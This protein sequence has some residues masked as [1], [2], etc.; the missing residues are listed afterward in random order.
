MDLDGLVL[1]NRDFGYCK[2]TAHTGNSVRVKF[3]G[4]NRDAWYGVQV[5]AAQKDFRWTP[6]PAGLK[7]RVPDRGLCT[8]IEVPFQPSSAHGVHEYLVLFDGDAGE[9]ARLT[10]RELWPIPGSLA[11]TPLTRL[12]SLQGDSLP[13]FRARE[14]LLAAFQQVDRESANISALAASRVALLP[15]QAFVIGTVID[16]PLWRYILAD[17]VGLGKTIEAGAIAHQLLSENPD[18]RVLVLCPG[19]LSRQWLCE[20][21]LSFGGRAFRLLDL[22]DSSKVSLKAWPLV[23]SSL[24]VAARDYRARILGTQWDMVIVDEAHQLLW[25]DGHYGLVEQ[26]A[27]A[28]PRLLLLS[29]VPAR[30]RDTELM[31]LLRMIEPERYCEGSPVVD[32]FST[33]Y[34]A[35]STIGRRLRIV[36]RQLDDSEDVDHEQLQN[37]VHRLLSIDVLR[38]DADLRNLER[39]AQA[40][41]ETAGRLLCYRQLVDEVVSRYR[42]S[43]RI[44]KNRRA[45]LVD[46]ELLHGVPRALITE[47]YEPSALEARIAAE[48]LDLLSSLASSSSLDALQVLFRKVAQS[49]CDPVG[50]YEIANALVAGDGGTKVDMRIFDANAAFD[51]DE[52][53]AVLGGCADVFAPELDPSR[54]TRWVSL[55]RAAI[56]VPEQ[57]RI[58]ALKACLRRLLAEGSR[59]LLVFAGTF[60]AAE[61]VAE[62][63][64]A[65]FGN[66]AVASFRHDLHDDEKEKQVARF[67]RD[68][69]CCILV[70]DESGG[71]GRNFQFADVLVHFDLPWSV[72]AM[73]QRIGRLDRIGRDR[74]VRSFVIC[75]AGGLEEA[76]LHCLDQGFGVFTRS[77]SGLE[78]MLHATERLA[79]KTAVEGGPAA[80]ADMIP[81]IREASERERATDDAEALT[82]A[83]SFRR[84]SLYL[85]ATESRADEM[86]EKSVP[87]YLRA[88][89]RGDAARR[90]TDD[91]DPNLRIWRLRPEE[92][93]DYKLV[94]LERQGEIPLKDCH[95]TFSR[96]VARDRPDLDFFGI[97]HPVVDA[98]AVAI[99]Q[100]I[101]GRSLM[102]RIET[103]TVTPG[104]ILL[105]AWRVVRFTSEGTE[106]LTER[107]LRLVRGR[108]VWGAVD[109]ETGEEFDAA[110]ASRLAAELSSE[111]AVTHDMARDQVIELVSPVQRSW[112][113]TLNALMARAAAKALEAYKARYGEADASFCE[114]L[115]TEAKAVARTRL[116]EGDEYAQAVSATLDAIQRAVLES[117]VLC[118]L[119][120]DPLP[121]P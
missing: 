104:L 97:G 33:L 115:L 5:V 116:D 61:Y 26:L 65:D 105:S 32:Q 58:M 63:L 41:Q 43:R 107:A 38:E 86:L 98:L 47:I 13:N 2:I 44:L 10:E 52:Q 73:E 83:A 12:T 18:A 81:G 76:W 72:S 4:T 69:Q 87:S 109:L 48:A 45:R 7:C 24:K 106:S 121:Q 30:E 9:T 68:A 56:E 34:A 8:I 42:I 74:P 64:T 11:E 25:N 120:V 21:H 92:V 46:A 85:R 17:E 55:L 80:L 49:L 37:D 78:F 108:V 101:R 3:I 84:T 112:S 90:V 119:K 66:E 70:S 19:P 82:D 75:P 91:K 54:L 31:R 22:H 59:K 57:A 36:S 118:L 1:V 15:H 6:M 29:A 95:G 51:Y 27:S 89:G 50:L 77:I 40:T 60:G 113:A 14:G 110:I 35:Q 62:S 28:A 93:T 23:I 96:S 39:L 100:H 111:E 114:Q 117:D 88:I 16:D 67:K 103:D 102:V 99:R 71:E 20:M 94:G 53:D 79:V